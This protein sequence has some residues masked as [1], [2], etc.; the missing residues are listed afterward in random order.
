MPRAWHSRN[1]SS[2]VA[3]ADVATTA[4]K[5]P[6]RSQ[7]EKARSSSVMSSWRAHSCTR[8]LALIAITRITAPVSIKASILLSAT[9]SPPITKTWRPL[10]FT[11]IGNNRFISFS[12]HLQAVRHRTGRDIASNCPERTTG[13]KSA[14]LVVV[15]ASEEL[16]QVFAGIPLVQIRPQKPLDCVGHLG[17][18]A[19]VAD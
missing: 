2:F 10:S 15:M 3:E 1:A 19:A 14:Q 5:I 12:S 17:C 9:D 16:A 6:L 13:K 11:N 4:R 18:G 7:G 8:L